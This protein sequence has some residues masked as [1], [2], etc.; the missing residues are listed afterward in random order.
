MVFRASSTLP[1]ATCT[2]ASSRV[3]GQ[4]AEETRDLLQTF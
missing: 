2:H 1:S 3:S 4:L